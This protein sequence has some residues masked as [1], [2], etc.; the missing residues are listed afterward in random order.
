[1]TGEERR[2][3]SASSEP[4]EHVSCTVEMVNLERSYEVAVIDEIQL[5]SDQQRG[6]AWTRAFLGLRAKEIHLC[7][8]RT[9]LELI[10]DLAFLTGDTVEVNSYERLTQLSFMGRPLEAFKNVEPGDCIVC[11]NKAD[12]FYVSKS[13]EKIGHEVAVI[14]GEQVKWFVV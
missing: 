10:T 3:A 6:W 2:Y 1:M 11:F 7:G 12:I 14:Y 4:A 5:I 8:D 13:L 9:A